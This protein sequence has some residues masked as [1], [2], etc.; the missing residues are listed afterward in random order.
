M[1]D[2]YSVK[3]R[4]LPILQCMVCC[5][6][7]NQLNFRTQKPMHSLSLTTILVGHHRR[8]KS[9]N[10]L[11]QHQSQAI[12]TI[13]NKV[14][15]QKAAT[16][17]RKLCLSYPKQ[18]TL[19]L[20]PKLPWLRHWRRSRHQRKNCLYHKRPTSLWDTIRWLAMRARSL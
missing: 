16:A 10:Q 19:C 4:N 12:F 11:L 17:D 20:F 14:L 9:M 13:M 2:M 18:R 6:N 7:G 8:M 3:Y 1:V 5:M 15:T